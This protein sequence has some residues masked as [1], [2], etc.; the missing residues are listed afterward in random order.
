MN[1]NKETLLHKKNIG[2]NSFGQPEY[3]VMGTFK[4]L[5]ITSNNT[6]I[7]KSIE[8]KENTIILYTK[9]ADVE[10]NDYVEYYNFYIV[11]S[12]IKIKNIYIYKLVEVY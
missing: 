6:E 12:K 9:Y 11:K 7:K 5:I 1:L 4:G 8:T 3:K 2:V 10:I